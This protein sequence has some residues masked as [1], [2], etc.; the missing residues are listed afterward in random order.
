MPTIV[1][2]TV[3]P[4]SVTVQDTVIEVVEVVSGGG[5]GGGIDPATLTTKGDILA[6]TAA[7]TITRLGVG[8][9]GK[10]LTADSTQSTGLAWKEIGVPALTY[11]TFDI[12][13]AGDT[14][15][16]TAVAGLK[17]KV[18]SLIISANGVNNLTFK[19][20]ST[21]I[22]GPMFA[23]GAGYT[24]ALPPGAQPYMETA[25]NTAL[26]LTTSTTNRVTVQLGYYT[27]A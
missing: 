26:V 25:V 10:V 20:G 12:T 16:K 11:V 6:A 2:V 19:S 3:D 1:E 23:D 15:L 22:A 14:T 8:S 4:D 5:S 24:A 13:T 27:E 18:G 9:N 21:V 17:I 7:S